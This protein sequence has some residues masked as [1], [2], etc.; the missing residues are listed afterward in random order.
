[1]AYE[2]GTPIRE[3][4][5]H[6]KI[7]TIHVNRENYEELKSILKARRYNFSHFMDILI[8]LMLTKPEILNLILED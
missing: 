4:L 6:T 2:P 5:G 7:T 8:N 1:M 3:N